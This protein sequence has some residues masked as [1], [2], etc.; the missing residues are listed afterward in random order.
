[1]EYY[2]FRADLMVQN[3]EGLTK[4]YNRDVP[5][6]PGPARALPLPGSGGL[7]LSVFARA[8]SVRT[9]AG[10]R[11]VL[12]V[13]LFLVNRDHPA[14]TMRRPTRQWPSRPNCRSR[15]HQRVAQ[16]AIEILVAIEVVAGEI[17]AAS[18]GRVPL[19]A[20]PRQLPGT[21]TRCGIP[22]DRAGWPSL[23]SGTEAS[24]PR[25]RGS[26]TPGSARL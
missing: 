3:N 14:K 4:T 18:R 16:P 6:S 21:T 8:T 24:G 5:L 26:R 17:G 11:R 20:R 15:A 10:Q 9:E 13:S 23:R 12:A 2:R 1:M 25:R 19:D 22:L 7:E